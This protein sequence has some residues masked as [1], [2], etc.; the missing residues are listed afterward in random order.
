MFL[1]LATKNV[2]GVCCL[3]EDRLVSGVGLKAL[4]ALD[5]HDKR[6]SEMLLVAPQN[7]PW[8]LSSFAR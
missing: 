8:R 7:G 4:L 5:G 6:Q 2:D 3:G 1:W